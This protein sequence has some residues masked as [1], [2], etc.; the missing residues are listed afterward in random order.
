MNYPG[1][2]ALLYLLA[3]LIVWFAHELHIEKRKNTNQETL[4]QKLK[5]NNTLLTTGTLFSILLMVILLAINIFVTPWLFY[6]KLSVSLIGSTLALFGILLRFYAI[7]TLSVHFDANIQIKEDQELIQHG[8]F[9]YIR[10]PS[11]TGSLLTFI[12]FGI[13]SLNG[14]TAAVLPSF[15]FIV[16]IQRIRLEENVL[17]EGF[18]QKYENYRK[19]TGALFPKLKK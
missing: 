5:M 8:L 7:R 4:P 12:G 3:V 17:L 1:Y 2:P 10:H 16:Y 6:P 19:T 15:L 14:L 18:G 9:R 13:G 11:Y